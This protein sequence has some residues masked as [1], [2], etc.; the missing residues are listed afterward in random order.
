MPARW[1][2]GLWLLALSITGP[3]LAQP[4]GAPAVISRCSQAGSTLS[5]IAALRRACPGIDKALDQLGLTAL[6]PSGWSKSLTTSGLADVSVLMGR[7]SGSPPSQPPR[8]ATLRSIASALV[9]PTPPPT[10]PERLEAW[11]KHW[12][13]PLLRPLGQWLRSWSQGAGHSERARALIYCLAALLVAAVF[14]LAFELG[15]TGSIRPQRSPARSRGRRAA[16][17]SIE[18]GAAPS[19]EPDWLQ[20][21]AS[22]AR[23]LRLLVA[24]LTRSHRLEHDRHLTCRELEAQARLDTEAERQSFARI[25]RLAE[26]ELYGPPGG[27]L[28]AEQTLREMRT[29]YAAL[30]ATASA[31][32]IRR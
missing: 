13:A 19:S 6:L 10:W 25:A 12:T 31:G 22:P 1:K 2:P 14:V 30:R 28:L 21:R 20:L 18:S 23:I 8:A 17:N 16:A 32:E 7:Y 5:G 11:I 26:R 9:P 3:L 24:A 27:N 15:G 4:I 29:L